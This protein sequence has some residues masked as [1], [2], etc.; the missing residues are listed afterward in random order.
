MPSHDPKIMFGKT[1]SKIRKRRDMSQEE[2]AE[3][4]N[5]HRNMVGLL[6][7]GKRNPSLVTVVRLAKALRVQPSKFFEKL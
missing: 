1:L 3:K 7:R 6:E 5:L 2:L 4:A